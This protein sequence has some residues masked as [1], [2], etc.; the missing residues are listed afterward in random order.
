[1]NVRRNGARHAGLV[2]IFGTSIAL[3]LAACGSNNGGTPAAAATPGNPL[4]ASAHPQAKD[5]PAGNAAFDRKWAALI[6]AAQQEGQLVIVDGP[7]VATGEGPVYEAFAK[8]YGLRLTQITGTPDEIVSRVLAE[9]QQGLHTVDLSLA[10]TGSTQRLL[11]ANV[12]QPLQPLLISPEAINRKTGWRVNYI[13]WV[14][15]D[16]AKKYVIAYD[17]AATLNYVDRIWYNTNNVTKQDLASLKSWNDLL[18]PKYKHKIVIGDV[19]MNVASSDRDYGWIGLGES[20]WAKFM[21]DDAPTVLP[22]GAEL[23]MSNGLANGQWDFA[24]FLDEDTPFQSAQ[25]AGLPIARFPKTLAP[26][27]VV[28]PSGNLGVFSHPQDP[29]AAKLFVNW[30]LSKQGQAAYNALNTNLDD[31]SLRTDVPR[32]AV[33]ANIFALAINPKTRF[34]PLDAAYNAADAASL[35]WWVSEFKQL[36]AGG[37]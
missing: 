9:K 13:P 23:Q 24:M 17:M 12:Y 10:G 26:G 27:T 25:Q 2:A 19:G 3:A 37:F 18:S 1:M 28:S 21:K 4:Y 35:S 30:L 29:A 11:N 15:G 6:K 16:K 33:P 20:Y 22:V 7:N 31:M 32:G 5:Y 8:E 14:A 36:H 34:V